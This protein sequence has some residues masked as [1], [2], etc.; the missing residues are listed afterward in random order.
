MIKLLTTILTMNR[1]S[2]T[3]KRRKNTISFRLKN[4]QKSPI[5]PTKDND[6]KNGLN[7]LKR[8]VQ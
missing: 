3:S 1:E 4:N 7:L 2:E 5:K 6:K 8:A